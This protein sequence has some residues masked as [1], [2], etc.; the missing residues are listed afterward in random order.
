MSRMERSI[1]PKIWSRDLA[2]RG[3]PLRGDT[4]Q[5]TAPQVLPSL[6]S[7]R[8]TAYKPMFADALSAMV[9]ERCEPTPLLSV[10]KERMGSSAAIE[11]AGV[12]RISNREIREITG[13]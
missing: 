13:K 8:C 5:P 3:K 1:K 7:S 2:A 12:T 9:W 4:R 10:V 6:E 11:N